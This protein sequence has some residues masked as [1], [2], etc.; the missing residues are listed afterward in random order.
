M[1]GKQEKRFRRFEDKLDLIL[2]RTGPVDTDT[3]KT[4][5]WSNVL[6]EKDRELAEALAKGRSSRRTA[7]EATRSMQAWRRM[8]YAS[9]LVC[10]VILLVAILKIYA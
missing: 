6:E 10:I 9:L 7:D 2:E 3:T 8:T 4:A 1:N 5:L